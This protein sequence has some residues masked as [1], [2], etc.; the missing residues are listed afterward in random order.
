[1]PAALEAKRW[2]NYRL[3][4]IKKRLK[5]LDIAEKGLPLPNPQG[6]LSG[7]SPERDKILRVNKYKYKSESTLLHDKTDSQPKSGTDT[8]AFNTSYPPVFFSLFPPVAERK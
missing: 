6:N 4:A 7:R 5:G 3:I 1:L 2:T 8:F